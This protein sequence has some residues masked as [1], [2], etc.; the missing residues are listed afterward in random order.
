MGSLIT[1][2]LALSQPAS[3]C[4]GFFCNS[5]DPVDQAGE[6]VV[7]SVDEEAGEVTSHIQIQFQGTARDFAWI[8]PV[9]SEPDVF[10][11]TQALFDAIHP[12]TSNLPQLTLRNMGCGNT[13]FSDTDTD[14]D[15]DADSD[16]DTDV[17][18]GTDIGVTV[19]AQSTV[20][21]Y[22]TA[23]LTATNADAL[24]DWLQDNGYALPDTLVPLLDSYLAPG[25]HFLALKLAKEDNFGELAPLG[26]RYAGTSMAVPIQLTAVAATPD[27]PMTVYILGQDRAVPL[28]YL[29]V[30]LNPLAHDWNRMGTFDSTVATV[31]DEAGGHAFVTVYAGEPSLT[32]IWTP[33]SYDTAGLE[34]ISA[35]L[36]WFAALPGHGFFGT[37]ELL[38]ILEAFLPPPVGVD[39]TDFYNCPGCYPEGWDALNATFDSVAA[40]Q[41]LEARIVEPRADAQAT[42]NANPYLTRL[43]TALSPGEMT[44]DPI[45]GFNPDLPVVTNTPQAT[46]TTTCK[47]DQNYDNAPRRL[48]L[49]GDIEMPVPNLEVVPWGSL[50]DWMSELIV[51]R[52]MIIEQLSTS[53]SGDVLVDNTAVMNKSVLPG[54]DDPIGDALQLDN[55]REEETTAGCA[56]SSAP[57]N[58]AILLAFLPLLIGMRR[59]DRS[60]TPPK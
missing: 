14:A 5:I 11:S 50:D 55:E 47:G 52:A 13:G 35:P 59:S 12:P 6:S 31:A 49:P 16:A 39:A 3:A 45:F 27:M 7:F 8:V 19:V 26:M 18:T 24:V 43:T 32:P 1:L 2:A 10:L 30:Q 34:D 36:D 4:G 37:D 60:P 28:N 20:G 51:H 25:M 54:T 48:E 17:D 38:P 9:P 46:L 15:T 29:H 56:C 58:P 53:G 57:G 22:D 23:T 44:T 40:S 21:P 41:A 33:N 42:L